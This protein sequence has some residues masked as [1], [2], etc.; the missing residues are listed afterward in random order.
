MLDDSKA[1]EERRKRIFGW[2]GSHGSR[3]FTF[4]VC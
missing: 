3:R 4:V 2:S 1:V